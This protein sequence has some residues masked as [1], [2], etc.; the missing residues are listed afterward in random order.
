MVLV[1]GES[2]YVHRIGENF[3]CSVK[4]YVIPIWESIH[5][6]E[7]CEM[8]A[9]LYFGYIFRVNIEEK[10][11]I[12]I[13]HLDDESFSPALSTSRDDIFENI[14][15]HN[16]QDTCTKLFFNPLFTQISILKNI[17]EQS[18]DLYIFTIPKTKKFAANS[19]TMSKSWFLVCFLS[20]ISN[21]KCNRFFESKSNHR[22]QSKRL[23]L[24]YSFSG[25]MQYNT[26][27]SL[28]K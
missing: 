8:L 15:L 27:K 14:C 22:I 12:N 17:V 19:N 1:N 6:D 3:L 5:I 18:S 28:T 25:K 16:I 26:K 2:S 23:L 24:V 10:I 11:I 20:Q 21:K 4:C 13:H 7:S 9:S